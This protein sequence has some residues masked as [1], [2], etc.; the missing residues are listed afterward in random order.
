MG[1]EYSV[2]VIGELRERFREA[3]VL[4]PMRVDRYDP[5]DLLTYDVTGVMPA[6]RARVRLEVEKFIGG[7]FAGQVY[8]ARATRIEEIA[9][10]EEDRREAGRP[11]ATARD[12]GSGVGAGPASVIPG[13][14]IGRPLAVKILIPPS[15]FSR[16]F[17]NALYAV[18]FQSSFQQ[19]VNPAAARAGALWVKF[20]RRGAGVRMGGEQAVRDVLATFVDP[21]LGACGEVSEWLEGRTWRFEVD[22]HLIGRGRRAKAAGDTEPVTE[23]TSPGGRGRE[24]GSAEYLAK[25]R[26][27]ADFVRLLHE[28]GAAEL[29]RQYEWWTCKSQ[30]NVLKRSEFDDDPAGGLTAL[31]FRAGLAL[32]ALLPMSPGDFGLILRGLRRGRLVQ[33]DRGDVGKL[34]R[35]IDEHA[36]SFADMG[37]ALAE[38][39]TVD[40][41]YRDSQLDVTGHHVRLL[42]SAKLWRQIGQASVTGWRVR[43][44]IDD[45]AEQRLRRSRVKSAVFW[46][47]GLLPILGGLARKVWGHA[48]W[49]AHHGALLGGGGYLGRAVRAR[50]AEKAIGWHRSGRIGAASARAAAT[51]LPRFLGHLALSFLPG[52]LHRMLTDGAWARQKL[53]YVFVRPVRLFFNAAARAQWLRDMVAEGRRN[54]VLSD[55]DAERI[56]SRV[57]EPFIQKYLK[58]LAVHVATLPLSEVVWVIVAAW[59]YFTHPH[60]PPE[61]RRLYTGAVFMAFQVIPISP[62]SL[63]RGLY[64]VYLVIRERNIRDYGIAL[65]LAFFKG[66]GYLAFP[67]QMAYRYPELARFMAAHWA[68]SAVHV[69]PVFGERGALLEHAVFDLFYNYPLTIRRRMRE[70]AKAREPL[71]ARRWHAAATVAAGAAV[72]AA[73]DLGCWAHWGALPTIRNVW[74]AYLGVALAA[75]GAVVALA[76]GLRASPRILLGILTGAVLGVASWAAHLALAAAT[77]GGVPGEGMV[78]TLLWQVFLFTLMAT[79]GSVA[80]EAHASPPKP[81]K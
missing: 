37:E 79:L 26:F 4:R 47:L 69:V 64:V 60:L 16:A 62:G 3:G 23:V 24:Q 80:V 46:M 34:D 18:G 77:A 53:A 76:G 57:G 9:G 59:Y 41:E 48:G 25:K 44:I 50:A 17:R 30:P 7:G 11:L 19:Q 58:S 72:L 67:I 15:R 42:Y 66:V 5:G 45:Q 36:E 35:F 71:P 61:E 2:E 27:M 40:A 31:D 21:L 13:L 81:R 55:E 74:P 70:A 54:H 56:L 10:G 75:S 49:R 1:V 43:N 12:E 52:P 65:S 29:A 6:R 51:S 8:R 63:V 68:T 32:L 78:G 14:E 28:M 20:I 33:F 38:L 22:D 73:V 39:K